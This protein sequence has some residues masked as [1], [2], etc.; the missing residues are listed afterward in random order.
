MNAI[1][2][3][4]RG[5][6]HE[7]ILPPLPPVF[8]LK[9]GI[10]A[11]DSVMPENPS[12]TVVIAFSMGG[13]IATRLSRRYARLMTVCTPH[14]GTTAASLLSDKKEGFWKLASF[15]ANAYSWGAGDDRNF[16]SFKAILATLENPPGQPCTGDAKVSL[17][18]A[19]EALDRHPPYL[20][21]VARHVQECE[22]DND[23]LVSTRSAFGLEHDEAIMV[24][25]CH[26]DITK[27][28]PIKEY[29]LSFCAN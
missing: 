14:K 10:R 4:I 29:I 19:K 7:V 20:R 2:D 6:G 21:K 23:G 3:A 11:V 16:N 22:G 25:G 26:L 27:G 15:F 28:T 9:E 18:A 13:L 12:Q 24:T 17:V 1:G 8:D 5:A